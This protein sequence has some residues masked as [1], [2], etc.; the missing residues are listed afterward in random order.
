MVTIIDLALK[1]GA[2]DSFVVHQ[3][4]ITILKYTAPFL[5]EVKFMGSVLMFSCTN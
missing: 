3:V 5:E 1:D 4:S 2:I